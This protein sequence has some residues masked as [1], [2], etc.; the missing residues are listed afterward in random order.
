MQLKNNIVI[1]L[2]GTERD[3]SERKWRPTVALC[4]HKDFPIARFELLFQ[5]KY[6]K[7]AN[8]VAKDIMAASPQTKVQLKRIEFTD[9]WD[10]NEVYGVLHDF[11]QNHKFDVA[12]ED[13]FIHLTTGT[14][15]AQIS[16]FL[17]TV[18]QHFPAKLV[19]TSET[20][21]PQGRFR[22]LDFDLAQYDQL[23]GQLRVIDLSLANHLE[24]AEHLR[25]GQKSDL[26]VLKGGVVTRNK[27]FDKLIAE[28]A[29]VATKSKAPILLTGPTGAGK[30][31]LA[32]FIYDLKKEHKKQISG[33][34]V[35]VNCATLRG[36]GAMSALFGHVR[37]AFTGAVSRRSGY[38]LEAD[39]GLLF[40]DEI[41]C[42]GLDEQAMLLRAIEDKKFRPLGGEREVNS[43]F[44]LIVG[45]N[46]DLQLQVQQG[47]F[48]ADLLARIDCWTFTLPGLKD[49]P[50]DIEPN[51]DYELDQ[52]C[53]REQS[54]VLFNKDAKERFLKFAAAND[55]QWSRNF[56]DLNYAVERMATL[57]PGGRITAQVAEQEIARLR[58]SWAA[59]PAAN[60][61]ELLLSFLSHEQ[62]KE[63]DLYEQIQLAAILRVCRESHTLSDAGR[64]LYN[65][66]RTKKKSGQ[67]GKSTD[68]DRLSKLLK[69]YGIEP[70]Q[71]YSQE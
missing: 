49:R 67:A 52:F 5:P 23:A 57:A 64:K 39:K 13:Y 26:A 43:D 36:D 3:L 41:G 51:L 33:R 9:P 60:D 59:P 56:R 40:L 14:H 20:K 16:L 6:R 2:L 53:Q 22:V 27:S 10:F 65:V 24:V 34:F 28:V 37:G 18:C 62:L 58:A 32:K 31:R 29:Q 47:S 11:A 68:S 25:A 42:L 45:T 8:Q 12:H 30:S 46:G 15:V 54:E 38:L 19:Q 48:R 61:R 63:M 21:Q 66:S 4:K 44:Q 7:L 55:A 71:V 35:E 69:R 17:L 70:K 50:E 1:G